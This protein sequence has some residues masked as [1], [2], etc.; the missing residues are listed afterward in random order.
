MPIANVEGSD[1]H[2]SRTGN[3]PPMTMLLPQAAG[4]SVSH[5]SWI[6]S[7]SSFPSFVTIS[8]GQ[9]KARRSPPLKP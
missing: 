6:V 9:G 8:A 3:G 7:A 1:I 2:Y 4:L 5:P